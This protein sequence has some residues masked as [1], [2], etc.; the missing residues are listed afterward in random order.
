MYWAGAVLGV[1]A[2][3]LT[4]YRL[5]IEDYPPT[6]RQALVVAAIACAVGLSSLPRV[7]DRAPAVR[8][9]CAIGGTALGAAITLAAVI[10]LM[11]IEC[12]SSGCFG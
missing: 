3:L 5:G 11:V 10:A 12:P 1:P 9:A 8:V 6:A 2:A 4:A 7:R